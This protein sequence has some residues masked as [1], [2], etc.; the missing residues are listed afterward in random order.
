[1]S[2]LTKLFRFA[3]EC[4]FATKRVKTSAT[5]IAESSLKF[6]LESV[7]VRCNLLAKEKL[8]TTEKLKEIE[9]KSTAM[10]EELDRKNTVLMDNV[11]TLSR[12]KSKFARWFESF[13]SDVQ[14]QGKWSSAL[15]EQRLH[16]IRSFNKVFP[17]GNV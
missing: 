14:A 12:E 9:K 8:E 2:N 6:Q 17:I 5:R 1:M 15:K 4:V 7:Q 16:V 13:N 3:R 11:R 10:K